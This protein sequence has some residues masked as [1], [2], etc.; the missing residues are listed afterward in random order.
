MERRKFIKSG[1]AFCLLG[2][3]G[4]LLPMLESCGTMQ[5]TAVYKTRVKDKKVE[6]P[7][8]LFDKGKIQFIR[9]QGLG[10][11]VAVQQ[12]EDKTYS[13]LLMRCTHMDNPLS[14]SGNSYHCSLHG[15]EFDNTG[16]VKKGPAE[17]P[18][19]QYT[20]SIENENIVI[21]L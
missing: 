17:Q 15:S 14:F 10:Y 20:I 7:V 21:H 1:C 3:T 13:A 8:A 16:K 6:V 4:M 2:A 19:E 12:H 11:D 18:L 5:K 9:P